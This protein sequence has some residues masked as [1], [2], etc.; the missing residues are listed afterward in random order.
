[1]NNVNVEKNANESASS[2][3]RRFTKRT[4]ENGVLNRVRK[5]RYNQRVLSH[6][7]TKVATLEKLEKAAERE[8]LSKLGKLPPRPRK[9]GR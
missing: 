3:L 2:L 1:M 6:Y 7:K 9:G 5:L 4:Q 8:V